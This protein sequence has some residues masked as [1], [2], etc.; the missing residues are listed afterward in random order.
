LLDRVSD[1]LPAYRTIL[2]CSPSGV[3]FASDHVRTEDCAAR[4]H[5]H[6]AFVQ[7]LAD[8]RIPHAILSGTVDQRAERLVEEITKALG[9]TVKAS[10]PRAGRHH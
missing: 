7:L 10:P 3:A 4:A 5:L 2:L 8:Y 6:E 9:S 1:W